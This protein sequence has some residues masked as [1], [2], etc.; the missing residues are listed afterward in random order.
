M[1][2]HATK[3]CAYCAETI[4]AGAVKCRYCGSVVSGANA[5][6][7]AWY[8]VPETKMIAGV[9]SGLAEQFGVSVT[10]IR[11]AFVLGVIVGWGMG[12]V[13][14]LALW[15]IMPLRPSGPVEVT[16]AYRKVE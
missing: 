7:R 2:D 3:R 11:L 8:R 1:D 4:R 14:Y 10:I 6:T 5:L 13:L 9:C 15:V 12:L 16:A